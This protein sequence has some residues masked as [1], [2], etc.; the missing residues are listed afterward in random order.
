MT[1]AQSIDSACAAFS[2]AVRARDE[3]TEDCPAFNATPEPTFCASCNNVIRA[4][5]AAEEE[6]FFAVGA[7][8]GEAYEVALRRRLAEIERDRDSMEGAI[9]LALVETGVATTVTQPLVQLRAALM[10]L[11]ALERGQAAESRA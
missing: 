7:R 1:L 9:V 6:L 2:S 10:R 8:P 5:R 4:A 11:A 3:H